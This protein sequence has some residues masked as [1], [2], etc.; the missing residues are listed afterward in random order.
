M[1]ATTRVLVVDDATEYAEM[2]VELLRASAA[3][4]DAATRTAAT[5]DDALAA[6][7]ADAFD[8]AF[9]DY[10]LGSRDGIAL[11]R[12]VRDRGVDTPVVILTGQGAEAVA[13]EAMKAGAADYLSKA[14]VS[15]ET[16][17]RA[18]R[19]ALALRDGERQRRRAEEALKTSEERFRALVE[20]SSDALIL[21]DAQGRVQYMTPT[22]QR[23]LGWTLDEI[24]GRSIFDVLHADDRG[25][26][27]GAMTDTLAGP[28][29]S[30]K[31]EFRL[32]HADG[33]FKTM[34]AI[35]INHLAE[36]SVKAIVINARDITERRRLEDE[37][38]HAQ[39]MDAVGQLA[40]GLAHDF[41]NLLT[42]ILG[43]CELV[44]ADVPKD[45]PKRHDLEEIRAAGER[46]ASLTRQ[47]LAFARRQVLQLQVLDLNGLV[48]QMERLLRRLLTPQIE[49][50][51]ELAL[52]LARVNADP[53]AIEQ[54]L[55]ALAVYAR[56][57][58]P[59]GGRMT[60]ATSNVAFDN[61]EGLPQTTM[62]PGKYV[63]LAVRDTGAG[64][65]AA[66]RERVFEPF[67]TKGD[68]PA[69]GGL[70]LATV[71]GIVKQHGGFI[72]VDSELGAGSLFSIYLPAA[73]TAPGA[74]D[75]VR[76]EAGAAVDGWET[77]LIVEHDDAVR[78]LAREVLRRQGY[79][80][81]EARH[82]IDALRLAERH[83]DPIHLLVTDLLTPHLGGRDI[84]LRLTTARPRM[85]VLFLSG[86]ASE[87]APTDE[88]PR[89]AFLHKPFTPE[90]LARKVR[91]LLDR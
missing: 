77:V 60:I 68:Q 89:G 26:L 67:F 76:R 44:L 29:Q 18:L 70:G 3:G 1:T 13:V 35:A 12:E 25:Q 17:D 22:S 38:G 71:Y 32:K 55:V 19:H 4:R 63:L 20:H 33:T 73:D 50:V 87:D 40:G 39:K 30:L 81:I 79:A 59:G 82:G 62:S 8:V 91:T 5:Y 6:L 48:R 45:D 75:T 57:A 7:T 84:A 42:A 80:V 85:K 49:L 64:M 14:D 51:T 15:V 74:Q 56:D 27:A 90:A 72:A 69:S 47:L 24:T 52:D 37:L 9:V 31:L 23:A 58:M 86:D 16:I 54:S 2:V 11:L 34:D 61:A 36:P 78:A 43:Y 21:V 46:A 53:S 83:R 88:L 41:T 66:T 10:L 28:G 65:D